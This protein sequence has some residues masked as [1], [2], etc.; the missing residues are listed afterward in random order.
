MDRVL[1]IGANGTIGF[2]IKKHLLNANYEVDSLTQTDTD[3]SEQSLQN[4][5][6]SLKQGIPFSMI[7]CCIGTLHN[8]N[9]SPEKRLSQLN[10]C[11][12]YTSPSPRDA[13]LS[14]MPS[15]A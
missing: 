7:V 10:S 6:L 2:A 8:D 12:L 3:Y 14:R 13:T 9:L 4:H 11:L 15:S 5:F 1:V